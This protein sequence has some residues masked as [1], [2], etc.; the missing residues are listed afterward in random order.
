MTDLVLSARR[1]YLDAL[2]TIERFV[3]EAPQPRM[4]SSRS[5]DGTPSHIAT[6]YHDDSP[7]CRRALSIRDAY[8]HGVVALVS[9]DPLGERLAEEAF[10]E[11]L[12]IDSS[13]ALSSADGEALM[14]LGWAVGDVLAMDPNEARAK[15]ARGETPTKAGGVVPSEF[16]AAYLGP[17]RG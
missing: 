1:A 9:P 15:L 12:R 14:R 13:P 6:V 10:R 8:V 5:A 17:R 4:E 7:E 11:V 3:R 16:R 2:R